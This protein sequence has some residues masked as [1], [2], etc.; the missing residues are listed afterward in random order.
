VGPWRFALDSKSLVTTDLQGRVARWQGTDFQDVQPLLELGTDVD[1]ACISEDVGW[2]AASWVGGKVRVWDLHSQSLSCEF[3]TNA[4]KVATCQFMA[5]GSKLMIVHRD[6]NSLHEWDLKSR[7]ET[8]SWPSP[9]GDFKRAFSPDGQW[10]LTSIIHPNNTGT[11]LINL[12]TGRETNLDRSWNP[13]GSFSPE[14]KLF[15][16]G[17]WGRAARLWEMATRKEV[18]TLS[19]F[20]GSVWSAAF[21]PDTRRLATGSGGREAIKLWDVESHQEVLTWEG[22]GP[23]FDSTAFSPDGNIIGSSNSRGVL[24]L[25]RAPSWAEIEAAERTQE[26]ANA[27][28]VPSK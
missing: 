23:L 16:I 3:T 7:R 12:T 11:S 2:L 15:A 25:W 9:P 14:G 22:Q 27:G 8:R 6:D 1:D 26:Q 4:K 5:D 21:S 10:C 28:S 19:D 18:A 17:G 20:L 13:A 24:H